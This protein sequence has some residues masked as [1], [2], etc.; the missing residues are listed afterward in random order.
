MAKVGT[1]ATQ[2]KVTKT[3]S[4]PAQTAPV[5]TQPAPDYGMA[6]MPQQAIVASVG[7]TPSYPAT[8]RNY[9]TYTMS[10]AEIRQQAYRMMNDRK[11]ENFPLVNDYELAKEN[12]RVMQAQSRAN[13]RASKGVDTGSY[14]AGRRAF[15]PQSVVASVG[16]AQTY[17]ATERNYYSY[18]MSPAQIRQQAYDMMLDRK[19]EN[20]PLVNDYDLMKERARIEAANS[21]NRKF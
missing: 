8:E 21:R 4:T 20:F 7:N 16:N 12:A 1:A 9:Y 6:P 13:K 19:Y 18:T 5:V 3:A 14:A 15:S 17:P 10:P 2:K 11:Y